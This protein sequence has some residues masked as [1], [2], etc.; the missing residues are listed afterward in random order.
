MSII[1]KY[2][3]ENKVIVVTGGTGILGNAFID[4]IVVGWT[5]VYLLAFKQA[6]P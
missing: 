4:A 1:E 6:N 5:K 2:S 3:L